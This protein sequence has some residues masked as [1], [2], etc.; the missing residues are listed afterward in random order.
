M[1]VHQ[2]PFSWTILN[3]LF[4]ATECVLRCFLY[5]VTCLLGPF[6]PTTKEL[7]KPWILMLQKFFLCPLYLL[8]VVALLSPAYTAFIFRYILHQFR[9]PYCLSVSLEERPWLLKRK[10]KMNLGLR[11]GMPSSD[12]AELYSFSTMNLCLLPEL[13]SKINNLDKTRQRARIVGERIV[14]DQ[15]FFT[16]ISERFWNMQNGYVRHNV[17]YKNFETKQGLEEDVGVVSHFSHL[18][19]ICF[20]ETFDRGL[21]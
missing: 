20:Q 11:T 13:C 2:K 4:T 7:Q 21:C 9:H 14:V 5:C 3:W 12:S 19:F 6:I 1:S 17:S 8:G 16:N 18:D 15:F 10:R